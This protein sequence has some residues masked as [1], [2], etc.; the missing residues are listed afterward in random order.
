M[1]AYGF[2]LPFHRL[3][4]DILTN[5]QLDEAQLAPNAWCSIY[6]FIEIFRLNDIPSPSLRLFKWFFQL[7]Y[8]R[9]MVTFSP[10]WLDESVLPFIQNFQGYESSIK[11]WKDRFFVA[12][13]PSVT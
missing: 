8:R 9:S 10:R 6:V 4:S 7:F 1:F 11:D 12:D 13:I 2:R 5:L 3:V